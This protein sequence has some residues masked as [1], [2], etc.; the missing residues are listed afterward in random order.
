MEPETIDAELQAGDSLRY[1]VKSAYRYRLLVLLAG[2]AG[3][4]ISALNAALLPDDYSSKGALFVRPAI[5]NVLTP[6]SAFA[7]TGS[8]RVTTRESISNELQMLNSPR[9]FEKAVEIVGV[10]TILSTTR[11]EYDDSAIKGKLNQIARQVTDWMSMP[12][13]G[14]GGR[15]TEKQQFE[16]A[17]ILLSERSGFQPVAGSGVITVEAKAESPEEAQLLT[18][19]LMDAA[20]ELHTEINDSMGSLDKIEAE[21]DQ[22]ET[23]AREAERRR[24]AFL[25][26]EGFYDFEVQQV[27]L[28]S[29]LTT[30]QQQ[31]DA[32]RLLLGQNQAEVALLESL[33]KS[34]DKTREVPGSGAYVLNPQVAALQ[35]LI[36]QLKLRR[37]DLEAD[38]ARLSVSGS[39]L[40]ERR[41]ALE[42][43]ERETRERLAGAELEIKL[44]DSVEENPNYTFVVEA[45]QE[46]RV[47]IRGLI[48]KEAKEV[49]LLKTTGDSLTK[50]SA[51]QPRWQ[52]LE[53]DARQKR[54]NAD[55]LQTTVTNMRAVRRLEQQKLSNLQVMHEATFNPICVGPGRTK[56]ALLGGILGGFVGLGAAL[57]LA[58][59]GVRVHGTND[60]SRAGVQ[61]DLVVVEKGP[62]R[63]RAA[64]SEQQL[65][66]SL[67]PM[68][69]AI[70]DA[71]AAFKFDRNSREHMKVASLPCNSRADAGRAAGLLA[72]GLSALAGE[73][74]VYVS[75]KDDEGWLAKNLGLS[76]GK[77]WPDIFDGT[78]SLEDVLQATEVAGLHY[79]G[80]GNVSSQRPH[81]VSS[82]DFRSL[83]D[84]LKDRCR[85]VVFELPSLEDHPSGRAV[86]GMSDGVQ[87]SI[88]DNKTSRDEVS[89]ALAAVEGEGAQLV[90]AWLQEVGA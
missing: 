44:R 15:I 24:D 40:R 2:A 69:A 90:C 61:P 53:I 49:E 18:A 4:V 72:V 19:A 80:V 38:R 67:A 29:Y 73:K 68:A 50:L 74:V 45:L 22:A 52:G 87:L 83:V 47:A 81:P 84:G 33:E 39:E 20:V 10:E 64:W 78:A 71:F 60:V 65:P 85:F 13:S 7:N 9:L 3:F 41:Q 77:G 8:A 62:S 82:S 21:F 54:E 6:E 17:A 23:L 56:K 32:T 89:A 1:L 16:N 11:T 51:L 79:L 46:R 75:C 88:L 86:L 55:R 42:E 25:Q 70:A 34:L 30:L 66:E 59:L 31:L 57:A 12:E 63:R 27:G 36:E 28:A 76:V 48:S 58:F 5:R 14:K 43:I 37:A 26:A 35:D